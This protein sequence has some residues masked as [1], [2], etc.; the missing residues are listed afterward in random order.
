LI[1]IAFVYLLLLN[2]LFG[3]GIEAHIILKNSQRFNVEITDTYWWGLRLSD[4]RVVLH[5][6][7]D[8]IE[9]TSDS[10]PTA[11]QTILPGSTV[12]KNDNNLF[13]IDYQS[14]VMPEL[15]KEISKFNLEIS[16]SLSYAVNNQDRYDFQ[17]HLKSSYY[18][19]LLGLTHGYAIDTNHAMNGFNFGLGFSYGILTKNTVSI[20]ASCALYTITTARTEEDES[21]FV[22]TSF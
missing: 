12:R 18:F 9:T 4:N 8:R 13:I 7:I 19:L 3:N 21:L 15:K 20:A 14:A 1:K 22:T 5:K 11:I 16:S 17:S 10:L 2:T 6:L